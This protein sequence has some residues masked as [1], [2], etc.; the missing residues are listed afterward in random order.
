[1]KKEGRVF[2]L[3]TSA[4]ISGYERY[5]ELFRVHSSH[6]KFVVNRSCFAYV[7]MRRCLLVSLL[8]ADDGSALVSLLNMMMD[9]LWLSEGVI[10]RFIV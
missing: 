3:L 5:I 9:L 7:N 4:Q 10:Y 2:V 1:M 8:M 6:L